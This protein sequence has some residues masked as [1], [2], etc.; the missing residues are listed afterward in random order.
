MTTRITLQHEDT[1][2]A[3]TMAKRLRRCLDDRQAVS[4]DLRDATPS[5]AYLN[6]ALGEALARSRTPNQPEH[7]LMTLLYNPETE[8][9]AR[10]AEHYADRLLAESQTPET[11]HEG[12]FAWRLVEI[13]HHPGLRTDLLDPDDDIWRPAIDATFTNDPQPSWILEGRTIHFMG[14]MVCLQEAV[15]KDTCGLE[16]ASLA[17]AIKN[18]IC[19]CANLLD[20]WLAAEDPRVQA[21]RNANAAYRLLLDD[22]RSRPDTER[23]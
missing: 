14:R 20:N 7:G 17:G 5:A 19:R 13:R 22:F 11:F 18:A 23:T 9:Y 8:C 6:L 16:P 4:V 3:S 2:D 10:L 1:T 21:S 15:D 12:G